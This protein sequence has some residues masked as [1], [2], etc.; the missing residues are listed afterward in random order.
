MVTPTEVNA[1]ALLYWKIL[2][3]KSLSLYACCSSS[4]H[5]GKGGRS[6]FPFKQHVPKHGFHADDLGMV[7]G[8]L[9]IKRTKSVMINGLCVWSSSIWDRD[10]SDRY[11]VDIF[12][13]LCIVLLVTFLLLSSSSFLV[14]FMLLLRSRIIIFTQC[15]FKT[16]LLLMISLLLV[17]LFLFY[18]LTCL[19]NILS[20]HIYQPAQLPLAPTQPPP[21]VEAE[22]AKVVQ[23]QGHMQKQEA[24]E[25]VHQECEVPVKAVF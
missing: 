3:T 1:R 17:M 21:A 12:I 11:L 8:A 6:T 4:G 15:L 23:D 16:L 22:H 24:Q 13:I 9:H 2:E 14:V 18:L 10:I 7:V 5:A 25:Q 20:L 19:L